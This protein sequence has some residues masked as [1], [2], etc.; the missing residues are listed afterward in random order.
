MNLSGVFWGS[1]PILSCFPVVLAIAI[2]IAVVADAAPIQPAGNNDIAAMFQKSL[3]TPNLEESLRLRK[4]IA[5]NYPESPEGYACRAFFR[6]AETVESN[7]AA[8]RYL[9]MAIK[10]KPD[11]T[12]AYFLRGRAYL[13]ANSL[14]SWP[15]EQVSATEYE[16]AIG[17][18]TKAIELDPEDADKYI[19]RAEAR[20]NSGKTGKA[21]LDYTKAISLMPKYRYEHGFAGVYSARGG[22]Y[23]EGGDYDRA[24]LDFT[25]AIRIMPEYAATYYQRGF[26]YFSKREF[27]RANEDFT[28]AIRFKPDFADAYTMRGTSYYETGEYAKAIVDFTRAI[29]MSS[30]DARGYCRRGN[31]YFKNGEYSLAIA[32]YDTSIKADPGYKDAY[33]FRERARREKVKAGK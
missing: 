3:V 12:Y 27:V 16:M 6:D 4:E 2:A 26:A 10:M 17:D 25:E 33:R 30:G 9:S 5:D 24:I 21:I 18:F 13:H 31:A 32:D 14:V 7:D 15:P 19:K 29:S 1:S 11:F 20:A 28:G 8:I 23:L 22:L